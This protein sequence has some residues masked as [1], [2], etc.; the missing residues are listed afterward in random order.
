MRFEESFEANFVEIGVSKA[1]A[2]LAMERWVGEQK[3]VG[4]I[5]V[6]SLAIDDNHFSFGDGAGPVAEGLDDVVIGA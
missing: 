1:D 5:V 4:G 6:N 2:I 3:G